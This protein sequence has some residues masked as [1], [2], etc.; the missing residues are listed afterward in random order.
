MSDPQR[1]LDDA[2]L[3]DDERRLLVAGAA[4]APPS[5]LG[6]DVWSSLASRL[7]GAG[8]GGGSP[9]GSPAGSGAAPNGAAPAAAPHVGVS[10]LLVKAALAVL[11]VGALVLAGRALFQHESAPAS[12]PEAPLTALPTPAS[13][14]PSA[15][16]AAPPALAAP[17]SPE[18]APALP[19][20]APLLPHS[21]KAAPRAPVTPSSSAS[22]AS[23]ESRVVAA[24]RDALHSGNTAAALSLLTSAQQ[25][26]G[27]GVLGQE[28][29]ALTIEALAKSGQRGAARARGEAFLKSY[30]NSPYAA[31]IRSLIGSN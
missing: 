25:R 6:A 27:S 14:E 30:A 2:E 28:R 19:S 13:P 17:T 18:A 23:E 7:P 15:A 5:T 11:A 20:H 22:D 12:P 4:M 8:P 3:S 29:E 26:F 16:A 31:R 10:A 24:A 21:S 1:L 9:Q